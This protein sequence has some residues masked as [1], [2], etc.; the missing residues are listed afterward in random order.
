MRLVGLVLF[1]AWLLA[2]WVTPHG[3]PARA[4]SMVG[5]VAIAGGDRAAVAWLELPSWRRDG[6]QL[7]VALVDEDNRVREVVSRP[8]GAESHYRLADAGGG[9][10]VLA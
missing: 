3:E 8:A 5:G 2:W 1:S 9:R 4:T 10:F 7:H 6:G